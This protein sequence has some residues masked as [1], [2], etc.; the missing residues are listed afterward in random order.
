LGLPLRPMPISDEWF[1]WPS[2]VDLFPVSF[3]GVHTGRDRFLLNTLQ[4]PLRTRVADYFDPDISND[5]ISRM[6]PAAMRNSTAFAERDA[7]KV[8][9]SLLARGG[10]IESGFVRD[11]YRPFDVRWLYWENDRRL[12]TAPSPSYWQHLIPGNLWLSSAQH[13]RKGADEPQACVSRLAASFHLIERGA[14][15]FPLYLRDDQFG[16]E[17]DGIKRTANLSE[18]AR[19]YVESMDAA[20]EDLFH[21]V[22]ATLHDS[23]YREA[24]AGGLRMG[25]PRIPLPDDPADLA[26]SAAR[27][28]RLARLLDTESDVAD[29]LTDHTQIA[30]DTTIDGNP[31]QPDDFNVTAGW[32][33]FGANQAVMPGQGKLERCG[34]VVDVYLNDRAYWR[35][36]PI[37]VWEYRL[38]GYQVLKKWL[39]YRESKVLGRALTVGEV[40]WF[41]EVARRI[42]SNLELFR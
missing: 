4:D 26:Q 17:V 30:V 11:T 9:N 41:S 32:G 12:L 27:G 10:P 25:W 14:A 35:D 18:L 22:L 34:D 15:M 19:A 33:H 31:M 1:E 21:H 13:L 20:P 16:D 37:E 40:N 3:P 7:R 8:R 36:V 23:A 39:S 2:L 24:N 42:A 6:Y 29:L 38:G 28:H 5:A